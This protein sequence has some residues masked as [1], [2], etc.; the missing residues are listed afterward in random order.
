MRSKIEKQRGTAR[1]WIGRKLHRNVKKRVQRCR[2][3][4]WYCQRLR[5]LFRAM[6][7]YT[8]VDWPVSY[9][10]GLIA[11]GIA[12]CYVWFRGMDSLRDVELFVLENLQRIAF[13]WIGEIQILFRSLSFHFFSFFERYSWWIQLIVNVMKKFVV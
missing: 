11:N 4:S 12:Y 2:L 3:A 5:C 9:S 10:M 13:P 8:I 1:Q 7:V 6:L